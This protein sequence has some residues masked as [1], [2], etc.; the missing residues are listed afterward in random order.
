M[1]QAILTYVDLEGSLVKVGWLWT[2]YRNG[3]ESISFEYDRTWMSHPKR[4][5]IDPTLQLAEGSFHASA[6]K[7]LFGAL[8]LYNERSLQVSRSSFLLLVAMVKAFSP[9]N[10]PLS[11]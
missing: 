1:E 5:A 4:F 7:P 8:K 9:V 2:H 10:S 11:L 3:R 6:D